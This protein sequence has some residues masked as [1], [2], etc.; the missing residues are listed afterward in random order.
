MAGSANLKHLSP[1]PPRLAAPYQP[2][3]ATAPTDW[4]IAINYSSSSTCSTSSG[5]FINKPYDINIDSQNNIWIANYKPP[6][7]IFSVIRFRRPS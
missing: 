1:S 2:S 4:T 5:S 6:M 7:A 3:L